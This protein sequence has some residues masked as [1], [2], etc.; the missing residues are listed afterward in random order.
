MPLTDLPNFLKVKKTILQILNLN[1]EA[2]HKQ[3]REIEFG[4]DYQPR[5]IAHCVKT[6]TWKWLQPLKRTAE[7]VA[8]EVCEEHFVALLPFKPKR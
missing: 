8:K 4:P 1:P 2:Y 7:D 3:L 6:L 5:M